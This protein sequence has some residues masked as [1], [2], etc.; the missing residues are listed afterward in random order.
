MSESLADRLRGLAQYAAD[1][2]ASP[3][4]SDIIALMREAADALPT[5]QPNGVNPMSDLRER[6]DKLTYSGTNQYAFMVARETL[7]AVDAH[8]QQVGYATAIIKLRLSL[9]A[10]A[11]Q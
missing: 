10:P 11:S 2:P 4:L 9:P 3:M 5:Q 8:G 1:G 7:D 6:L